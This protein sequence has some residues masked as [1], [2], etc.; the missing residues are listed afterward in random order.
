[1]PAPD[2]SR[3]DEALSLLASGG[4]ARVTPPILQPASP[5][6]DLSGEELR[7]RMYLTSDSGGRE[8]CLRPDLTIPTALLHLARGD[9]TGEARY[10]Y[11]GPVF[12]F[13]PQGPD[14][15]TQGGFE[16]YGS[17]A[18]EAA[19]AE[20]LAR[21]AE[22]VA[23]WRP[24]D[25]RIR[26]GDVALFEAMLDALDL[27]PAWRRRLT[28]DAQ[29]EGG[30]SRSLAAPP[31]NGDGG[32][33]FSALDGADPKAARAVVEDLLDIAGIAQVGGRSAAEI[34]DRFLEKARMSAASDLPAETRAL[35]GDF[36]AIAGTPGEVAAQIR[37]L[38]GDAALP[39]T[40]ALARAL[41]ACERR[42]ELLKAHAL[43][44]AAI[45]MTTTFGGRLGYYTGLVFEL[46]SARRPD[47]GALAAG[48]RYDGLLTM[49][50]APDPVPAVGCA[51]WIERL[52]E[53]GR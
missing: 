25:I 10:S 18:A 36:F 11:L 50:G 28:R 15:F 20:A 1:M 33:L 32:A 37:T 5:F 43:D 22:L 3:A 53:A 40:E 19:D 49:L 41:D 44:P 26:I 51:L 38:A 13:R 8:L 31:A 23:L 24:G 46:L 6:L 16:I 12:R 7:R 21:A 29:R 42:E 45:E 14:E 48:G 30:L 39:S 52:V 35:L 17:A 9:A 2:A 34:A 47:L 4:Y 27:P